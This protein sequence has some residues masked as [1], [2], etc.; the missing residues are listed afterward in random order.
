MSV[1]TVRER[2][3]LWKVWSQRNDIGMDGMLPIGFGLHSISHGNSTSPFL[4]FRKSSFKEIS[5]EFPYMRK[6]R[7]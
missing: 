7:H 2:T 1:N 6:I 5:Q 4:A 3:D